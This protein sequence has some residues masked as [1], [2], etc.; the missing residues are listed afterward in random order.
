[1]VA[2]ND[3]Q[4]A[5]FD[6]ESHLTSLGAVQYT[7][8]AAG[9]VATRTSGGVTTYFVYDGNTPVAEF[10]SNSN[11]AALNA[12]GATGLVMRSTFP[13][14]TAATAFY[15]FDPRGNTA[16]R[17]DINGAVFDAHAFSA[18]G[19]EF[20]PYAGFGVQ[21]GYYHDSATDLDLLG[22]RYYDP[23]QGRFVNR[24]PIHLFGGLHPY[25]YAGSDPVDNVDPSG[26]M[27]PPETFGGRCS[28]QPWG[29]AGSRRR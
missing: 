6:D 9:H 24:D 18:Y 23:S 12:F 26:L 22:H 13:G 15:T 20:T 3:R 21:Y 28:Y 19:Q 10:D 16:L 29:R 17:T 11:P 8:D 14:G 27:F 1:M 7:Y 2:A 4:A 25:E 5:T